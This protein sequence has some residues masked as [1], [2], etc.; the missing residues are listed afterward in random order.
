MISYQFLKA[1]GRGTISVKKATAER[2]LDAPKGRLISDGEVITYNPEDAALA[3][4]INTL[5]GKYIYSKSIKNTSIIIHLFDTNSAF[6]ECLWSSDEALKPLF[7]L[8]NLNNTDVIFIAKSAHYN[9]E[10]GALWMKKRLEAVY[11]RS[12]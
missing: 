4:S 6:L 2:N 3:F 10:F 1:R 8:V 11:R 7:S 9:E 5:A 12:R